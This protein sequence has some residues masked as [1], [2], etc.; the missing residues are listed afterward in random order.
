M[1][2]YVPCPGSP[3]FSY[4]ACSLTIA[5]C[6]PACLPV[7]MSLCCALSPQ[8]DIDEVAPREALGALQQHTKFDMN[9]L[10]R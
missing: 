2:L 4:N 3:I 10:K 7:D 9:E 5:A 8:K 6:L 1:P